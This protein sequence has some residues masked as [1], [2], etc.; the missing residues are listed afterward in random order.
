MYNECYFVYTSDGYLLDSVLP[1]WE[2][3]TEASMD[4]RKLEILIRQPMLL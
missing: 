1:I 2:E 4:E 3:A